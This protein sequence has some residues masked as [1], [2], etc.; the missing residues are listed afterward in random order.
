MADVVELRR[1]VSDEERQRLLESCS[2]VVYTPSYEHF[3]I[4]PLEAMAAA[5]PVLAP[6]LARPQ[7]RPLMRPHTHSQTHSL[8]H[9]NAH[10]HAHAHARAHA[11]T[12]TCTHTFPSPSLAGPQVVAVGLGGPCETVKDGV[13][14]WLCRPTAEAFADAFDDVVRRQAAGTLEAVGR[15]AREHVERAFALEVFGERLEQHLNAVT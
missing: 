11:H 13:T 3:G 12:D 8:T 2:A 10:A 14:G 7:P 4:V 15:A 5:R 6:R 9:T 1:N